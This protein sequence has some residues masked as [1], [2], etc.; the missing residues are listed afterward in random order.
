MKYVPIQGLKHY[1]HSTNE[2]NYF[3]YERM[4]YEYVKESIKIWY[5]N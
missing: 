5:N 1:F 4:K 3:D 2:W